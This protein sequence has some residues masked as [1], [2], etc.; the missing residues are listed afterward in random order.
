MIMNNLRTYIFAAIATLLLA[1][2]AKS[3]ET[4]PNAAA[5]RYLYA[6]KSQNP[7]WADADSTRLG[8]YY[9]DI[10]VGSGKEV[11][12]NGFAILRYQA[13][14]LSGEISD[15]T[16]KET[17]K[18]LG[19]YDTTSYYG[20]KVLCTKEGT[21]QAG[22]RDALNGMKVGGRR[23]MLVPNWLMTYSVYS[24]KEEYKKHATDYPNALYDIT[25]VDFAE[26]VDKW[27][28][29]EIEKYITDKYGDVKSFTSDT[30]GFYY[31]S[32]T[33]D[34]ITDKKDKTNGSAFP[35]DTTIYI[36]FSKSERLFQKPAKK[37]LVVIIPQ[38]ETRYKSTISKI[39]VKFL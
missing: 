38:I 18:M 19:K 23:K 10:V 3:I 1:S 31:K 34:K 39:T 27:Q 14:D 17:A 8:A 2:C 15:Y 16:D 24:D 32:L 30:V 28:I 7:E 35:G 36:T 12:N 29:S 9:N 5:I 21:L 22:L 13:S 37:P 4:G 33:P 11:T 26:D 20:P 25:V 6:W